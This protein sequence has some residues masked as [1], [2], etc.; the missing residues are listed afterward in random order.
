MATFA[1]VQTG[2]V[3]NIQECQ[4]TDY[5]DPGYVW[6][7][8]TNQACADGTAVEIGCSYDGTTFTA[9]VAPGV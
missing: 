3:V 6:V 7:D 1:K 4:P 8:L 2:Y 5:L 9:P